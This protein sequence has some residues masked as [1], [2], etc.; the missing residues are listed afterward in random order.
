[1][2]SRLENLPSKTI[3]RPSALRRVPVE[4]E[5]AI[6]GAT[7]ETSTETPA[8][9]EISFTRKLI[10]AILQLGLVLAVVFGAY[11]MALA[12]NVSVLC[13]QAPEDE[14]AKALE[15]AAIPLELPA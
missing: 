12:A 10:T 1:M 9:R 3:T 8:P 5:V 6:P 15:D 4:T 11:T 13:D 7:P 2:R 14:L